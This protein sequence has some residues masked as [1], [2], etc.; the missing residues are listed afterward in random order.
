MTIRK[1]IYLMTE[2]KCSFLI[3]TLIS[4]SRNNKSSKRKKIRIRNKVGGKILSLDCSKQIFNQSHQ[5]IKYRKP[6]KLANSIMMKQKRIIYRKYLV[7]K[8]NL[9]LK[10]NQIMRRKSLNL[11]KNQKRK[12]LYQQ[13]YQN[14][15]QNKKKN[16]K[17]SYHVILFPLHN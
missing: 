16:Q 4:I 12:S 15:Y 11:K 3:V 2:L 13:K 1:M 7:Q 8:Y 14:K 5:T 9:N 17:I 10:K 6:S